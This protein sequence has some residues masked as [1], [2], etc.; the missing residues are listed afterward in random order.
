MLPQLQNNVTLR[1]IMRQ[2]ASR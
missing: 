2:D 1:E